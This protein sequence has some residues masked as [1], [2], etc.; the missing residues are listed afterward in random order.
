MSHSRTDAATE[1]LLH[2]IIEGHY[3][4]GSALPGEDA[5]A[6]DLGVS[7][8][9]ARQAVKTLAARGVLHP[10]QG[11]GTYVNDPEH[12]QNL[13]C[14]VA[15]ATRNTTPRDVGLHLL[16]ARRLVRRRCC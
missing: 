9:T 10:K 6:S 5:L 15:L 16:E 3:P 14:L 4:T 12:W 8:L 7:R 1:G 13:S 2:R 11:S